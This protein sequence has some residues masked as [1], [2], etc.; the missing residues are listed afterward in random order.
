MLNHQQHL[1]RWDELRREADRERLATAARRAAAKAARGQRLRLFRRR[2]P[3]T[4]TI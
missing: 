1:L 2:R 4:T 3:Q